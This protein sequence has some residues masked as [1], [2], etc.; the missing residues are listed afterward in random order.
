[1]TANAIACR[2][3]VLAFNPAIFIGF[4][5]AVTASGVAWHSNRFGK[6]LPLLANFGLGFRINLE[7]LVL[8]LVLNDI[9]A[10]PRNAKEKRNICVFWKTKKSNC[11]HLFSFD[12]ESTG[13]PW[14]RAMM[15][16]PTTITKNNL[17][18]ILF[19]I[20]Y[21][22]GDPRFSKDLQ[23]MISSSRSPLTIYAGQWTA[24][25]SAPVNGF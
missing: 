23:R 7:K 18:A 25:K 14:I 13:F 15:Q 17:E 16:I 10:S 22:D 4:S 3:K 2:S 5:W 9:L 24:N 21:L 11:L 6:K 1:M 20:T 8:S 12:F 19:E